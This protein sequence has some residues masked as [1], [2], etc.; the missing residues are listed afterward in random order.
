MVEQ[1]AAMALRNS[2]HGV[3][4]ELGKVGLFDRADCILEHP[5]IRRLFLGL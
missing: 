1:N 3:V 5:E 2:D 4:I